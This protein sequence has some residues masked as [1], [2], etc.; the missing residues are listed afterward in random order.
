[1]NKYEA[2]KAMAEGQKLTHIWFSPEEWVTIK[3]ARFLFEDGCRCTI[4][5]FWSSRTHPDW[6]EGW[7]LWID[8]SMA[9]ITVT[10]H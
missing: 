6:N 7:S 8:S 1:M 2:V 4:K 9:P 3:Q 10:I 5:E